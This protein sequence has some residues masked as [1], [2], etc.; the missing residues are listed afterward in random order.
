MTVFSKRELEGY[1]RIDHRDSPGF[2]PDQAM[3]A[4]R[5]F[6]CDQIGPGKLFEAPT[7]YCTHC[8]RTV[9]INPDRTRARAYCSKCDHD[10]CDWCG[11]AAK[12]PGYV[13]RSWA[14]I[15]DEFL[16][17]AAKNKP[18]PTLILP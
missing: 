15:K 11:A 12:A 10:I 2:T 18:A 17:A 1:V 14:E 3:A 9:I 13:H 7:Y 8:Q 5:G 6:L 16:N 4:G